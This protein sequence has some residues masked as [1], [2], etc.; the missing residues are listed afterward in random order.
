L[1][2]PTRYPDGSTGVEYRPL[3]NFWVHNTGKCLNVAQGASKVQNLLDKG[4][5]DVIH[6]LM[7]VHANLPKPCTTLIDLRGVGV[8]GSCTADAQEIYRRATK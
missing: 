5:Y 6:E 4:N 3:D 8:A 1:H 2:R 7:G